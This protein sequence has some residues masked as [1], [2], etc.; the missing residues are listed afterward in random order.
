[1]RV[2]FHMR[3]FNLK[4]SLIR[5]GWFIHSQ[6]C[7]MKVKS[8]WFLF[9]TFTSFSIYV[10]GT[11]LRSCN[12]KE[13]VY[14]TF[15]CAAYG[16]DSNH[17][18][19]LN[20]ESHF[21]CKNIYTTWYAGND[22]SWL[23]K[24][25]RI[26]GFTFSNCILQ[27]L[28]DKFFQILGTISEIYVDNSGVNEI[29]LNIFPI[30][31]VFKKL[32]MAHNNLTAL[33]E[34]LFIYA[35]Q[36]NIIDFS[37]NQIEK[38]DPKAFLGIAK[39]L[40]Y[41]NFTHNQIRAVEKET[42]VD[43]TSLIEL[44]LSHNSIEVFELNLNN[45]ESME[46][47]RLNNNKITKLDC[48]AFF[49]S[50]ANGILVDVSMNHLKEIDFNC[51]ITCGTWKL[52][53]DE[54]RLES[55]S[56]SS[57]LVKSLTSLSASRNNVNN[58]SVGVDLANLKELKLANNNIKDISLLKCN[59]LTILELSFNNIQRLQ[60]D[61]FG[62]MSYLQ[63]LDLN[64]NNLSRIDYG[65]FT[66]TPNLKV[67]NI[68]HNRLSKFSFMLF[69]KFDKLTEI[70][71]NDNKLKELTG[72]TASILPG[73]KEL[74]ISNNEFNCGYLAQLLRDHP[75]IL[76][77]HS[78]PSVLTHGKNNIYGIN[79]IEET[80]GVLEDI[81]SQSTEYEATTEAIEPV[82]RDEFRVHM[83]NIVNRLVEHKNEIEN[84]LTNLS[85]KSEHVSNMLN[86]LAEDKHDLKHQLSSLVNKIN[87][88]KENLKEHIIKLSNKPSEQVSSAMKK[89]TEDK[90]SFH[91][92]VTNLLNELRE[93]RADHN[94]QMMNLLNESK[95]HQTT[96]RHSYSAMQIVRDCFILFACVV[97]I[98]FVFFK[99]FKSYKPNQHPPSE[100]N[101]IY[102][103]CNDD[104]EALTG[105]LNI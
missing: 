22:K 18:A 35:T 100:Q 4:S 86:K 101:V 64:N 26:T 17:V 104:K 79:C 23:S 88:D 93:D 21:V 39:S 63:Y 75:E 68:S 3:L 16:K 85:N 42:F 38:I 15:N 34:Y 73:L 27:T 47:L 29:N 10:T 102:S 25:S 41:A 13:P 9:F 97:C 66:H 84:N 6:L 59:S 76:S 77:L 19:K 31:N 48:K 82:H 95:E 78:K 44:D 11:D 55:L 67:V 33:P 37:Y 24:S 71:L 89:L 72:W 7:K 46:K 50:T 91:Q 5:F 12:P 65:T 49:N 96:E 69:P 103:Q 20:E 51:N 30:G 80:E 56:L 58:F 62:N 92:N 81:V 54:N 94:K 70:H 83:T 105:K 90:R 28:P 2:R 36:M 61:S 1:M 99:L 60:L 57:P 14:Y 45:F 87:E 52:N 74:T 43:F 98:V 8:F 40:K 53:I 32:S